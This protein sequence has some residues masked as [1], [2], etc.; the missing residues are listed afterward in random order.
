MLAIKIGETLRYIILGVIPFVIFLSFFKLDES[1]KQLNGIKLYVIV[2][3]I[4]F[5]IGMYDGLVGPGTGTILIILF[6]A[7]CGY[8]MKEASGNAKI[9]NLTS[10]VSALL[11]FL[12]N[13]QVFM[14]LAIPAA[15][16]GITGNYIGSSL[17]IKNGPKVIRPV[18]Y[19]V[20]IGIIIKIIMDI[21]KLN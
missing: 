16:F 6:T 20:L 2:S 21:I 3:L 12:L 9:I 17:A 19:M 18:L 15:F 1:K 13:G 5:I 10:N 11:V 7:L 8:N 14:H 4:G